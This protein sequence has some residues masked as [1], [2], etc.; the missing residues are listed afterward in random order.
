[1]VR[2]AEPDPRRRRAGVPPCAKEVPRGRCGGTV[3]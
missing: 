1:M 2:L 3:Q